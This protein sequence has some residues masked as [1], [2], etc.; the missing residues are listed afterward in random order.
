MKS[1]AKVDTFG[2]MARPMKVSGKRTRCMVMVCSHGKMAKSTRA[3]SLTTSERAKASSPGRMV[4][5][6]TECGAMENSMDGASSYPRTTSREL[7]SG[8]TARR[9]AGF[10]DKNQAFI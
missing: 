10:H 9:S 5:S 4:E 6:M 2:P 3:T 1:R 7:E 8:K